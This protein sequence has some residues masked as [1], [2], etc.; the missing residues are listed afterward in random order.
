MVEKKVEALSD[1]LNLLDDFNKQQVELTGSET[2]SSLAGLGA[3]AEWNKLLGETRQAIL[4]HLR[5]KMED[6]VV[7]VKDE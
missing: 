7:A 3:V 2:S 5:R 6:F 4:T 1:A